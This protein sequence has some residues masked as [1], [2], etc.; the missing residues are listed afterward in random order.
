ML[1]IPICNSCKNFID[2]ESSKFHCKAFEDI[3]SDILL[4]K[5]NHTTP[6]PGDNGIQFEEEE[7]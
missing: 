5:N 1:N 6:Y 2:D 7:K 3:P 4:G